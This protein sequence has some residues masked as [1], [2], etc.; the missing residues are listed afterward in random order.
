MRIAKR[1]AKENT[2]EFK[3]RY[4]WRA[5]V[6]ATMSEY[7]RRTGVKHLR[8][9]GFEA[10][11]F[12]AIL[13]AI[14]INLFRATAAALCRRVKPRNTANQGALSTLYQAFFLFKELLRLYGAV[15]KKTLINQF[16]FMGICS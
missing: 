5:G 16:M 13:K 1:K 3:E 2:A 11:R 14:G 10:V 8:V 9:R 15:Y 7:D 6:E 12:C 4:R